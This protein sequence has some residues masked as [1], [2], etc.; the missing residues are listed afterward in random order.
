MSATRVGRLDSYDHK[1]FKSLSYQEL[2]EP[3]KA[4]RIYGTNSKVRD[5]NDMRLKNI[6]G[7]YKHSSLSIVEKF[8]KSDTKIRDVAKRDF[9]WIVNVSVKI[10]CRV[11]I[12]KNDPNMQFVNGSTGDLVS[13][14]EEEA[15]V[16]LD[17]GGEVL[18]PRMK[19]DIRSHGD[20]LGVVSQI[21]LRVS[22]ALTAHKV[23]GLTLPKIIVDLKDFFEAAQAYVAISRCT[24]LK[25]IRIDNWDYS[26]LF[27]DAQADRYNLSLM[28]EY[29]AQNFG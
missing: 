8:I 13:F 14:S 17:S 24:T 28:E 21:P 19:T 15:I 18:V 20:I 5:Y 1:I 2:S 16:R 29:Y 4:V 3:E 7:A 23:Q 12:L 25:G 6:P 27:C 26:K 11:M 10:G 22:Y 9:P